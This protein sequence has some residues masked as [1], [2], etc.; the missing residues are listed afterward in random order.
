ME[1]YA[2]SRYVSIELLLNQKDGLKIPNSA[3]VNHSFYKIPK[4]YFFKEII[5]QL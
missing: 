2:S 1:R 5:L 4:D 3:V